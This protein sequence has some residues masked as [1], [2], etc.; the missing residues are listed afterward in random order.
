MTND[1]RPE[2]APATARAFGGDLLDRAERR[3]RP[4]RCPCRL[5]SGGAGHRA[6]PLRG[7]AAGPLVAAAHSRQVHAIVRVRENSVAWI[8]GALDAAP[9]H[10]VPQVGSRREAEA[11]VAGRAVRAARP[12]RRTLRDRRDYSGD[13]GWYAAANEAVAVIVM[14]EGTEGSPR[15]QDHRDAHLDRRLPRTGRPIPCPRRPGRDRPSLS[16]RQDRGGGCPRPGSRRFDRG[17]RPDAG[18]GE[19]LVRARRSLCRPR[20]G[21]RAH[22]RGLRGARE[23]TLPSAAPGR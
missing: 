7:R 18:R 11:V 13:P 10:L 22:P 14:I 4:A 2:K 20:G 1:D 21:Y 16:D 15:Q 6:W 19:C 12:P 9:M 3:D 5:R 8:G 23:A 17:F